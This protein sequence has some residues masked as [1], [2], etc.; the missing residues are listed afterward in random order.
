[1]RSQRRPSPQSIRL[2]AALIGQARS[3]RYG[4]DLSKETQ[5]TPGTLYPLLE[6]L[7]GQGLLESEWRPSELDGR[8]PRHAYRLTRAGAA[9]AAEWTAEA[10]PSPRGKLRPAKLRPAKLKP[11]RG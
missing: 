8:P 6:R 9:F 7:E 1:M 10:D 5:L 3:W 4:Y 11:T 2:L